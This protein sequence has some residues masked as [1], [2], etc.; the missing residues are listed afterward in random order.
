MT[1][2]SKTFVAWEGTTPT[3]MTRVVADDDGLVIVQADVASIAKIVNLASDGSVVV[4]SA[5]LTVS[6]VVYDT[7]QTDARWK[8]DTT[9]Y[10]FA[11]QLAVTDLPT[12][13]VTYVVQYQFTG[14]AGGVSIVEF[15]IQT[16]E[17][18]HS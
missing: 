9:G 13:A 4:A 17:N 12:G 2:S 3:L 5:A 16:R 8:L 10:N 14:S 18:Y 6:A 15:K 7:L 11:H 1:V